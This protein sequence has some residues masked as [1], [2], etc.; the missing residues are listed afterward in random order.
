MEASAEAVTKRGLDM[1]H[2]I[3]VTVPAWAGF[4][5]SR[6]VYTVGRRDGSAAP[7]EDGAEADDDSSAVTDVKE[8]LAT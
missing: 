8:K 3:D 1:M 2:A 5:G 6:L 4:L 7:F